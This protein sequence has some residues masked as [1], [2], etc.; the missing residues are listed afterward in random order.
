MANYTIAL[1]AVAERLAREAGVPA[2]SAARLYLPL[3]RGTAANLESLPRP[4]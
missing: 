2:E 3:L 4:P 1:F